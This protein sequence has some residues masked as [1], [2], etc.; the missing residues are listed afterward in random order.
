MLLLI[1]GSGPSVA[2]FRVCAE[3]REVSDSQPATPKDAF[4]RTGK[5]NVHRSQFLPQESGKQ[6]RRC[7]R[8]LQRTPGGYAKYVEGQALGVLLVRAMVP[9][10]V[11]HAQATK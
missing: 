5:I 10:V 1:N 8:R 3:R 11:E 7:R 6:R 2:S 4:P 9:P